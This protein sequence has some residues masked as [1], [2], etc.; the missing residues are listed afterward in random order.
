M[1]GELGRARATNELWKSGLRTLPGRRSFARRYRPSGKGTPPC[2]RRWTT[3]PRRRRCT[4]NV[5]SRLKRGG[6]LE[7][8]RGMRQVDAIWLC[9]EQGSRT[10]IALAAAGRTPIPS[11]GSGACPLGGSCGK[12]W[13]R[14]ILP[15]P[16]LL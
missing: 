12:G 16:G 14:R 6:G 7:G 15:L 4:S 5:F 9:S 10:G 3:D 1:Q 2:L 8:A 11:P 13:P